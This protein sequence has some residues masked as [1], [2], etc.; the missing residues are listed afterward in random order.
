MHIGST[1]YNKN[2]EKV[3]LE[4]FDEN[5]IRISSRG[6]S[7]EYPISAMGTIFFTSPSMERKYQ[8]AAIETQAKNAYSSP[9]IISPSNSSPHADNQPWRKSGLLNGLISFFKNFFFYQLPA[10]DEPAAKTE[11]QEIKSS[12]QN[13]VTIDSCCASSFEPSNQPSVAFNENAASSRKYSDMALFLLER[14][15]TSLFHF[16]R[17]SNLPSIIEN[18]L[19]P[20]TDLTSENISFT[21]ND[22]ARY[23]SCKDAVCLSIAFPNY[24]MFFSLRNQDLNIDWVV[25][26]LDARILLDFDCAF[27]YSNAAKS[28]IPKTPL[29]TRK[30]LEALKGLYMEQYGNICRSKMNLPDSYPTDP[31]AEVL[32]FGRIPVSYIKKVHFNDLFAEDEYKKFIPESIC[33]GLDFT[34]FNPRHDWAFW[35][36]YRRRVWQTVRFFS[37]QKTSLL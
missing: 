36:N 24:K 6:K 28:E 3:T 2:D 8:D 20:R 9:S 13:A 12:T 17:A 5:S 23:D 4:Y 10:P 33:S 27:C 11:A 19:L 29:E 22:S 37:Q 14:D 21:Y 30:T 26:E 1:L 25:L 35:K 31:Q 32:V 15:I 7:F 16:T 34:F 18:G